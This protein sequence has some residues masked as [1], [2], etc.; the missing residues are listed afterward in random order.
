MT[1]IYPAFVTPVEHNRW[2]ITKGGLI[3]EW[4]NPRTEDGEA[5]AVFP[6]VKKSL[7]SRDRFLQAIRLVNE[8]RN[9]EEIFELLATEVAG[10]MKLKGISVHRFNDQGELEL[11]FA[12]GLTPA[13]TDRYKIINVQ[14]NLPSTIAVKERRTIVFE[15]ADEILKA[16]PT[17]VDWDYIPG[18]FICIPLSLYSKVTGVM[19]FTFTAPMAL[20]ADQYCK[21]EIVFTLETIAEISQLAF[22]RNHARQRPFKGSVDKEESLLSR[23]QCLILS[24]VCQGATNN[25]IAQKLNFS[26]ATIR[27]EISRIFTLLRVK[28]RQEAAF[29]AKKYLDD[30]LSV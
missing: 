8:G 14:Q 21:E 3:G 2:V 19:S 26:N 24:M 22:G 7:Y 16:F 15:S 10:R 23:R 9:C 28:N 11:K 29:A 27:L 12:S 30:E 25:E 13:I 6:E 17:A 1:I 18:T 5:E 20:I 4:G